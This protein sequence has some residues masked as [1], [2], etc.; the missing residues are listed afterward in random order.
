MITSSLIGIIVTL[1]ILGLILYC[2]NLLPL[3]APFG[4]I[5]NVIFIIIVILYLVGLLGI[6]I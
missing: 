1:V 3:P 5:I 2:I 6:H 4:T